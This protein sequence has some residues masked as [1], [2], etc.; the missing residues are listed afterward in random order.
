MARC[1]IEDFVHALVTLHV[2]MNVLCRQSH[3][4]DQENHGSQDHVEIPIRI[5]TIGVAL[6]FQIA[7]QFTTRLDRI[8][9]SGVAIPHVRFVQDCR[10]YHRLFR[11]ENS[12]LDI[13]NS[14]FDETIGS[15]LECINTL[16]LPNVAPNANR[17]LIETGWNASDASV[18][19]KLR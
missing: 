14:I 3:E 7:V 17:D 8:V 15:N 11:H 2:A 4:N 1:D 16:H 13:S 10:D 9:N 6:G 19:E 5:I 12:R 18:P